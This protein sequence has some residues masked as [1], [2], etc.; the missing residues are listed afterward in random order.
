ML[1]FFHI[2]CL[3]FSLILTLKSASWKCASSWNERNKSP[4]NKVYCANKMRALVLVRDKI[5]ESSSRQKF[6]SNGNPFER[7]KEKINN[8]W[9]FISLFIFGFPSAFEAKT[10]WIW[11]RVVFYSAWNGCADVYSLNI[12]TL[13]MLIEG[14]LKGY[15]NDSH[16]FNL[17]AVINLIEIFRA[18]IEVPCAFL[19]LA[20]I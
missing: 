18:V 2:F 1:L 9:P 14:S 13:W 17:S 8:L 15:V 5:L 4:T 6:T 11:R 12:W 16:R 20:I 7:S 19:A 3:N 10:Q